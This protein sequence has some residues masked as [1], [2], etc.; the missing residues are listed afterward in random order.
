[1]K[2]EV[3]D[4]ATDFARILAFVHN[5]MCTRK[6]LGIEEVYFDTASQAH[7]FV[8]YIKKAGFAASVPQSCPTT[9]VVCDGS[10]LATPCFDLNRLIHSD[11]VPAQAL[12][13]E[14]SK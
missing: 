10:N 9:V 7:A 5:T 6:F 11:P 12:D 3:F 14:F 2:R 1:M 4:N 13:T 8:S